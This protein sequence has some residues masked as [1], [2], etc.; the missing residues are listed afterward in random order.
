MFYQLISIVVEPMKRLFR[1]SSIHLALVLLLASQLS[2]CAPALSQTRIDTTPPVINVWYGSRQ[3]FGSVG[4][5]QKWI[6]ILGNVN[7][8][9]SDVRSAAFTING[10]QIIHLQ[11]GPDDRRLVRPGDFNIEIDS[12]SLVEGENKVEIS[13]I[14]SSG[15]QLAQTVTVEFQ[16]RTWPLP[17]QIDWAHVENVQEVLQ[18]VDGRWTWD[19]K[20]IRPAELGYDRVLAIGDMSWTEYEVTVPVT[21]HGIDPNSYKVKGSP[22]AGFGI[23]LHWLGHT[24]EPAKCNWPAQ[25]HCGW[26]PTGASNW[27]SFRQNGIDTLRILAG[28]PESE[29]TITNRKLAFGHTYIF[30][31]RVVDNPNGS[32][33]ALKVWEQD[34]EQEPAEWSIQHTT[35]NGYDGQSNLEHGSFLLVLHRVDATFG[36][37]SVRPVDEMTGIIRPFMPSLLPDIGYNLSVLGH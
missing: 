8:P 16:R 37:V 11:L 27:Y 24:D 23:N 25:P 17:Y 5:P 35:Q 32:I 6:N 18:I 4:L 30:K 22:G 3:V 12:S 36:N 2:A 34:V 28:P 20:G 14:N 7:D 13:A 9:E 29:I 26:E 33:Y 31:A 10:G 1:H 15:L 21:I 19:A